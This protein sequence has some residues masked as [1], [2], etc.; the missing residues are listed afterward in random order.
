LERTKEARA[1]M[2]LN[3]MRKN[4][5]SQFFKRYKYNAFFM[6]KMDIQLIRTDNLVWRFEKRTLNQMYISWCA[7]VHNAKYSKKSLHRIMTKLFHMKMLRHYK[8]WSVNA[9]LKTC[10]VLNEEQNRATRKVVVKNQVLGEF[11]E[12][13]EF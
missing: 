7:F 3:K 10:W 5:V 9:K 11:I 12:I 13:D 6:R 4:I 8:R 1:Q 2:I